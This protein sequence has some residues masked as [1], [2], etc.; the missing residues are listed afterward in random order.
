[1]LEL[2]ERTLNE[3]LPAVDERPEVLSAALRWA[4][5]GGGKRLRPQ[6]CL[7]AATAVGGRAED[8]LQP[9]A[10]IELL[11]SY[12]LVHDDLPCM[13]ND[14]ERRGKASVWAKFGEANAV[15]AADALQALAFATAAR[16]PRNVPAIVAELA[17]A[18][19]GVVAG[20]VE[21]LVLQADRS[22]HSRVAFVYEHKTADLFM[23]AAMMGGLAGGGSPEAIAALRAFALNL[24]L[25]FQYE[26]DLLDGDSPYSRAETER[27]VHETTA[28]AVSALDELPGDTAFLRDLA[29]KLIGRTV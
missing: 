6:I 7:A 17:R 26:D 25:A 1:M 9:A 15:L 28:A 19:Q 13:D 4:V 3:A 8:A 23:A 5:A 24:G 10:A 27:L 22:D 2:I 18:G 12:T 29:R 21:D 20:Q 14:V 16:A 11:H